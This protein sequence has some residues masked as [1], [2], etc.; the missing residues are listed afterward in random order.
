LGKLIWII[1]GVDRTA[2]VLIDGTII[3]DLN[4]Q[5][6]LEFTIKGGLR[7]AG[8]QEVV[9]EDETAGRIFGGVINEVHEEDHSSTTTHYKCYATDYSPMVD[10]RLVVETYQNMSA[11][12]IFLDIVAKYLTGFNTTHVQLGAP[13]VESTGDKFFYKPPS[14]CFKWLADYVGWRWLVDENKNLWFFFPTGNS[15]PAPLELS[16]ATLS[17]FWSHKHHIETVGLRNQ[18]FIRGGKMYSD[19]QLVEWK[20]D[21]VSRQWALPWSPYETGLQVGGE[22]KTVGIENQDKDSDYDYMLH[23]SEKYLR[24]SAGTSTPGEGV[25]L[26]LTAKQEID[27]ITMVEDVG[28]Q[29][30][31]AAI[32]GGDG[33]YQYEISDDGLT[34]LEAAE[35]AGEKELREHANPKVTGS[36]ET[37]Y[38]GTWRP[39][40]VLTSTLSNRSGSFTV[41]RVTITPVDVDRQLY[42]IVYGGRLL[43]LEDVLTAMLSTQREKVDIAE[44][45]IISKFDRQTETVGVFDAATATDRTPPWV[46]GDPDAIC[47]FVQV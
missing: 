16:E 41:Q 5:N 6:S 35:A 43:P 34:T 8:G 20:A 13:I 25:T 42:T 27:V 37:E 21:G 22:S 33:V 4:H 12:E 36:F 40:Q 1:A 46:C 14:E 24:C 15:E 17:Q 26:A 9:V 10:R 38:A 19:P 31:V 39:G 44:T 30:A 28:S 18:I 11:S 3:K 47:G 2:D 23:L 45:A 29:Q 7:P 32:E